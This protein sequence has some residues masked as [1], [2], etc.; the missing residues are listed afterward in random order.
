MKI[1][2]TSSP[3]GGVKESGLGKEGAHDGTDEYC[4]TKFVALGTARPKV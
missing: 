2:L 1:T 4:I 3:F